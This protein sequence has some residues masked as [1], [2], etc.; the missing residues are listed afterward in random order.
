MKKN[1]VDR[2]FAAIDCKDTETFV[3]FLAPSCIFRF[4]NMAP[5]EGKEN[6]KNVTIEFLAS[7]KAISHTLI[8]VWDIPDGKVCHGQV[9]YTR[10]D[11]S[12]LLIPFADVL[13]GKEGSI[14]QYLIFGDTSE[15]YK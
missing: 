15:L 8:E 3:N 9:E 11:D 5:V 10:K 1:W 7:I 6:I 14:T 2:M 4:G 12:I 13:K